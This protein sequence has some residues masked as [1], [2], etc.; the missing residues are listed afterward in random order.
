VANFEG[1]NI[2]DNTADDVCLHLELLELSSIAP[3]K[4]SPL[5]CSFGLQGG[6]LRIDGT[7][8]LINSNVYKNE[9]SGDVCS[10]FEPSETFHPSP[11]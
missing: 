9:A 6:G 11:R 1:C 2:H 10:H 5:A 4:R 7:A 8:T 3:M